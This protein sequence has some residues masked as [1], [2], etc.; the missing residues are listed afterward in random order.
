MKD[1]DTIMDQEDQLLRNNILK[2][3]L[4]FLLSG[5]FQQ[6][7]HNLKNWYNHLIEGIQSW[8]KKLKLLFLLMCSED[9]DPQKFRY[10]VIRDNTYTA[11][12]KKN[13]QFNT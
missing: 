3:K 9:L 11:D 7:I 6:K 8:E 13:K 4:F 5:A 12:N 10:I 1:Q 2:T